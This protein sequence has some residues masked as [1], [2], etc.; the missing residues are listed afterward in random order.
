MS[1]VVI[2]ILLFALPISLAVQPRVTEAQSV[3]QSLYVNL[4]LTKIAEVLFTNGSSRFQTNMA[5][6]IT[7]S[8]DDP[9]KWI[10]FTEGSVPAGA[11]IDFGKTVVA[12]FGN[13]TWT[14]I[15]T[16]TWK[17]AL[18]VSGPYQLP[19]RYDAFAT[20]DINN[21]PNE[22]ISFIF[23]FA[24]SNVTVSGHKF[25]GPVGMN[26][27]NSNVANL[28]YY[29]AR[30]TT[31]LNFTAMILG[32]PVQGQKV[33]L[34]LSHDGTIVQ[35]L[36]LI[37]TI[38]RMFY[39]PLMV[40]LFALVGLKVAAIERL[41]RYWQSKISWLYAASSRYEARHLAELSLSIVVFI[42]IY[43]FT[44][45]PY[46]PPW[47]S[48]FDEMI[49][50]FFGFSLAILV[51]S[52]VLIPFENSGKESSSPQ[53]S[54][55]PEILVKREYGPGPIHEE[56]R[57]V[58]PEA[59]ARY[60][61]GF[62][63]WLSVQS[64]PVNEEIARAAHLVEEKKYDEADAKAA[65]I[66]SSTE[67]SL[68]VLSQANLIRGD[69]AFHK[70]L[71]AEAERHY[72]S[73]HELASL[74]NDDF[75]VTAS[76]AGIGIAEGSQGKH[77]EAL[78][79]LDQLLRRHPDN[80]RVWNN[81][82]TALAML[83]RYEEA[84]GAYDQAISLD[85]GISEAWNGKGTTLSRL[86]RYEEALEAYDQAVRLD[87]ITALGWYDKGIL[88]ARLGRFEEALA[89]EEEAIRLDPSDGKPWA[90][91]GAALCALGRYEEGLAAS[92]QAL[93]LDPTDVQAYTNKGVALGLLGR[94]EEALG[95]FEEACRL[96]PNAPQSWGNK[97]AALGRLGRHGEALEAYDQVVR[98]DPNISEAWIGKGTA[99]DMLGK[100]EDA[101]AAYEKAI[102]LNPNLAT[103]WFLKGVAL[104]RLRKYQQALP[105]FDEAVRLDPN[106][107]E[108]WSEKATALVLLDR[109]DEAGAALDRALQ[110]SKD[111]EGA[112]SLKREIEKSRR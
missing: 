7:Y 3:T 56:I 9:P 12:A 23:A 61:N 103:A 28:N 111:H 49:I 50:R 110:I 64:I 19:W 75:L 93:R 66:I 14:Q 30:P 60:E 29:T 21:W 32:T 52:L 46:V 109:Y 2:L 82:G 85:S 68:L 77:V 4:S 22:N 80:A 18:M 74:A 17:P 92:E 91:K 59:V 100:S 81:K 62:S 76:A 36:G 6:E 104:C 88:L 67:Q 98:L 58:G 15:G 107:A 37:A 83:S 42:P 79:I 11:S 26:V 72:S 71:F 69:A 27:D 112:K 39:V 84:L 57:F 31:I 33:R 53:P 55:V 106:D 94:N 24:I 54:A 44:V 87:P 65:K 108:A 86:G 48:Y 70:R 101:L 97:G 89:A 8:G 41:S 51:A 35:G 90:E 102:Q 96:D 73:S 10:G 78:E 34:D 5:V 40:I 99:L 47:V 45:G 25:T 1:K 20:G 38:L 13:N 95:L 63:K 105:A 43:G 16:R